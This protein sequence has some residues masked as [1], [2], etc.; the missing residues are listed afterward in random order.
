MKK[1]KKKDKNEPTIYDFYEQIEFV[2]LS[3]E[4]NK[5]RIKQDMAQSF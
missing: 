1:S 4:S 5:K 2:G 3:D